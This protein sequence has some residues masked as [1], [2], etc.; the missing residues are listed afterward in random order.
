MKVFITGIEGFIGRSLADR[1]FML[2]ADVDGCDKATGTPVEEV[3]MIRDGADVV[4]HLA[5]IK[6]ARHPDPYLVWRENLHATD[7]ALRLARQCEARFVFASSAAAKVPDSSA[8]AWSKRNG[9][10]L[11]LEYGGT[12]L[13]FANVCGGGTGVLE[14]WADEDVITV[15]G[16][17]NQTRDFVH[18]IDVVNA[19]CLAIDSTAGDGEVIDICSGKQTRILDVATRFGKDLRFAPA[20]SGEPQAIV[21]DPWM[22]W[23]TFGWEPLTPCLPNL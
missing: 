13:R 19:L 15:Y 18:V 10:K 6:D 1:L 9:E 3:A 2:G 20:I 22:A 16:D 7:H 14:K 21:Q 11:V 12:V 4:V 23:R 17:G 8:Y 5:A